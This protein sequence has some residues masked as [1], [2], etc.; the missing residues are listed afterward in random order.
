MATNNK[1]LAKDVSLH[2]V[3]VEQLHEVQ[4]ADAKAIIGDLKQ[5]DKAEA[6]AIARIVWCTL[7][8][9][10]LYPK[11]EE[12]QLFKLAGDNKLRD[13]AANDW[14]LIWF[15]V[16]AMTDKRGEDAKVLAEFMTDKEVLQAG[17]AAKPID[18]R[19]KI[20]AII[21]KH[22]MLLARVLSHDQWSSEVVWSSKHKTVEL[23]YAY[24]GSVV[25]VDDLVTKS[26]DKEESERKRKQCADDL[27][28]PFLIG[29]RNNVD[30]GFYSWSRVREWADEWHSVRFPKPKQGDGNDN[31][32]DTPKAAPINETA[33]AVSES[34][35][36]LS[37][38]GAKFNN[39]SPA[40]Q[41]VELAAFTDMAVF[42]GVFIRAS[43]NT[44]SVDSKALDSI[45][46][47]VNDAALAA[48]AKS[49]KDDKKDNATAY[50]NA[51]L[52]LWRIKPE[53]IDAEIKRLLKQYKA[54][55]VEVDDAKTVRK[56]YDDA[57]ALM[58]L[59][60]Q[61]DAE[62]LDLAT[63]EASLKAIDD[64]HDVQEFLKGMAPTLRGRYVLLALR[65]AGQEPLSTLA[66]GEFE[67]SSP[68]FKALCEACRLMGSY[69]RQQID[70]AVIMATEAYIKRIRSN[71]A[72]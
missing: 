62:T 24:I 60:K 57:L 32:Q 25:R 6:S 34:L 20:K 45:V 70:Q 31:A 35:A 2:D 26:N 9:V 1:Q 68:Q 44:V 13:L 29:T 58:E 37:A 65:D 28:R 59:V 71:Q 42:L 19:D 30:D 40:M 50:R 23:P 53:K 55:G 67:P 8:H 48:K 54:L 38:S 69:T 15:S 18:Y 36:A 49:D 52:D 51:K 4:R 16:F 17:E 72:A 41:S 5:A 11:S 63:F 43:D 56:S 12:S 27:M 3:P 21:N 39:Q 7:R 14:S 46:A 33:K 64:T 10:A 22:R 66:K 61:F 47:R